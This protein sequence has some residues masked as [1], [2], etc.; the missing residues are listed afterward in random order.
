ME[1]HFLREE[2]AEGAGSGRSTRSSCRDKLHQ[3]YESSQGLCPNRRHGYPFYRTQ[4]LSVRQ[5]NQGATTINAG[6]LVASNCTRATDLCDLRGRAALSDL[7]LSWESF[8]AQLPE[9]LGAIDKQ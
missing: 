5:W 3:F 6:V 1:W 4:L 2:V 9:V 7:E 8:G